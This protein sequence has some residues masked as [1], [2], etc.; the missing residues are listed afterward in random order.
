MSTG[1]RS[2]PA[3]GL[4]GPGRLLL[5]VGPS[6]AGKDTVIA[7]A[8]AASAHDPAIVFPRRVVTRI[9]TEAEEHDSLDD[10]GFEHALAD[11]DFAF[12]WQAHGLRYGIPRSVD[13]DIRAGHTVI[14]NVSRGAVADLGGR[15]A[16]IV[17]ILIT[18]PA[19]ILAE[20]LSGRSRTSD[21]SL[22]QRV[23]RNDAYVNFRTD[24]TINNIGA[25]EKA[26]RLFLDIING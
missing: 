11:G 6:G 22:H 19:D 3:A 15:Y 5:V 25:P 2:S 4:I 8:K 21:G 26:V 17:A 14:C 20:R 18:A 13:D 12:W 9:A 23:K 7:G 16:R 24:Y 1:P 10:A